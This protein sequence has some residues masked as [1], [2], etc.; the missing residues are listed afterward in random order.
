[1]SDAAAATSQSACD[2]LASVLPDKRQ[3]GLSP[4]AR[5]DYAMPLGRRATIRR[6]STKA[7]I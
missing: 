1:M 3:P 4:L 7:E 2:R 5:C 6:L